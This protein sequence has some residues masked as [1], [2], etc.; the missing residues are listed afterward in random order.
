MRWHIDYLL[1]VARIVEV[2]VFPDRLEECA[3]ASLL[4]AEGGDHAGLHGFGSSDCRCE[5]HLVYFGA[6]RPSPPK[7]LHPVFRLRPRRRT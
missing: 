2:W 7:G 6:R 3:I 1:D 5:G 4:V